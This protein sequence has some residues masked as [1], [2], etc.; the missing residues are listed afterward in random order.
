GK[1][2]DRAVWPAQPAGVRR[3][4]ANRLLHVDLFPVSGAVDALRGLDRL[5]RGRLARPRGRDHLW[6]PDDLYQLPGDALWAL[7]VYDPHRRL[8]DGVHQLRPPDL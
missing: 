3:V 2:R 4:A 6:H 1:A 7:G 8:V 5:G